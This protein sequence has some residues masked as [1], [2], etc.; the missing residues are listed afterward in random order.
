MTGKNINYFLMDDMPTERIKCSIA[1]WIGVA[2]RIPRT[3]LEKCNERN[4]FKQS[5]VYFLFGEDKETNEDLVYVGQAS[6]RKNGEGI[7]YRIKEHTKKE[8][9]D[10]WAV[11]VVFTTLDNSFGPTEISWLENHFCDLIKK[12]K[13]CKVVN[14]NEP[15][16]GNPTEEKI[17]ELEEYA[18][19]AKM[20]MGV[21][22]YDIFD[23]VLQNSEMVTD[24]KQEKIS[25][26]YLKRRNNNSINAICIRTVKGFVVKN[27][28]S[29]EI[30]DF[31]SIPPHIKLK[32]DSLRAKK[33]ISDGVLLEDVLFTSPSAAAAFVLGT[34]A[35][36]LTEWKNSDNLK[37]KEIEQLLI[38]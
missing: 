7:L 15:N 12:A 17:S 13:R 25:V 24:K 14:S 18:E 3:T 23:P 9:K 1:N 38:K 29:I 16:P 34:S 36:G 22:G 8:D 11:A 26:L 2:Y 6:S 19:K 33:I 5:G 32:R 30:N 20:V 31:D 10:Y 35:N 37:L 4:H 27:G 28:S 21:L